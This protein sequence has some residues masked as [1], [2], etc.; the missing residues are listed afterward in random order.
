MTP[1]DRG[2]W[3]SAFKTGRLSDPNRQEADSIW[4][5]F[6]GPGPNAAATFCDRCCTSLA[7]NIHKSLGKG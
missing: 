7:I 5:R 2:A 3:H 1:A 4:E 6:A